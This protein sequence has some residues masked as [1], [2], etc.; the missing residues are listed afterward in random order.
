[1]FPSIL[2]HPTTK[3]THTGPL[4]YSEQPSK[5]LK[6]AASNQLSAFFSQ[7]NLLNTHQSGFRPGHSTET[8]LLAVMDSLQTA[9]ATFLSSVLILLDLSPA[10]DTVNHSILLSSLAAT[11]ICG[12]ALDWI[13]SYF[14]AP[15]RLPGLVIYQPLVPLLLVF[16]RAQ[17]S[18]PSSSLFTIDPL[19]PLSLLMACHTT[20]MLMIPNSFSPFPHLTHSLYQDL[21]LP[22]RHP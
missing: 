2:H 21:C 14:S 13:K 22:E 18:V 7:N 17:S 5:M 3:E 4:H 12:M 19:V 16:P 8:A 15:P 1:M 11:G 6:G 10:L 20:V 9:Q